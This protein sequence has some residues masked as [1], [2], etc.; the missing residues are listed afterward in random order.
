MNRL[1]TLTLMLLVCKFLSAQNENLILSEKFNAKNPKEG[2]V[3][4]LTY[5]FEKDGFKTIKRSPI[6]LDSLLEVLQK[7]E[8]F[9]FEIISYSGCQPD[10]ELALIESK[11]RVH[12]VSAYLI[13][14]GLDENLINTTAYGP[15]NLLFPC[16]CNNKNKE[17][18]NCSDQDKNINKRV[19][20]ILRE[21]I[22]EEGESNHT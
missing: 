13:Y 6:V 16:N 3:I 4:D 18:R 15:E 2:Q 22:Q 8:G 21:I 12:A 11:K 7:T 5:L 14:K 10:P 1:L 9:S 19:V 17:L 20:L